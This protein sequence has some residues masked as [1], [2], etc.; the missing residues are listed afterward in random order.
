VL[1]QS[2]QKLMNMLQVFRPILVVDEDV[3]QIHDQKIIGERPQDIVHHPHEICWGISQTKGHGKPF[4]NTFFG[5]EGSFPYICLL[6]WDLMV[7]RL[8]I[9]FTE[10]F[11]PFELVKEI[12]DSGNWVLVYDCDFI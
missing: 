8:H 6:Y 10:V 4:K 12:V 7:A 1:L 3:I 9:N 11:F 2:V 5:L